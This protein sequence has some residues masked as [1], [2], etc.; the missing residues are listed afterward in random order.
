MFCGILIF[1]WEF[2]KAIAFAWWP[3]LKMVSFVKYLV[4]FGAAFCTNNS[5][6]VEFWH[7]FKFNFDVWPLVTILFPSVFSVE[8]LCCRNVFSI[9]LCIFHFAPKVTIFQEKQLIFKKW[10]HFQNCQKWPPSTGYRLCKIVTLGPKLKMHKNRAKSLC[11]VAIFGN[12][13]NGLIFRI[14]AVFWNRFF[15]RTTAMCCRNAFSI[16]LCIFNFGP[17]VTIL[18]S[19]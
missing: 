4:L 8:Q 14:L 18:Q 11:L 17:K 6:W 12:F 9:F 7:V 2:G 5:E 15:H 1:D 3:I 16:F 13:Q 10:D 19:L